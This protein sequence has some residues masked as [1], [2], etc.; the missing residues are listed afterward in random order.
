[1]KKVKI[2]I[3]TIMFFA[4]FLLGACGNSAKQEKTGPL[5]PSDIIM[6]TE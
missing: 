2:M 4:T 1:M 3:V 6:E 5:T